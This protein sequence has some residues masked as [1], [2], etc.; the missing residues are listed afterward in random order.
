MDIQDKEEHI[1][2]MHLGLQYLTPEFIEEGVTGPEADLWSLGL[3][4]YYMLTGRDAFE[5]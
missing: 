2:E 1:P 5:G 4:I 3:I